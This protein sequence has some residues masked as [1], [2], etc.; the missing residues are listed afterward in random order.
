MTKLQF[1][2]IIIA[3]FVVAAIPFLFD[4]YYATPDDPRYIGLV[5]GAYTG[6]PQRELIYLGSIIGSIEAFLYRKFSDLEWYSIIYNLL[7]LS[8][9]IT[10]ELLLL[11]STLKHYLKY[12]I[13]ALLLVVQIYLTL[14]PQFTLLSTQLGFTS[15]LIMLCAN[16]KKFRYFISFIFFFFAIQLRFVA[17]FIPFM[18]ACPL[19]LYDFRPHN[20]SWWIEKSWVIG[21]I[22]I[23]SLSLIAENK[24]YNTPEWREFNITNDAR[25]Y[26]ADNPIAAEYTG[27]IIDKKERIAYDLFYR[28]RIFD[29]NI[30]TQKDFLKYAKDLHQRTLDNIKINF[31]PYLTI[32]LKMGGGMLFLTACWLLFELLR[33]RQW[34]TLCLLAGSCMLFII[35]NLHMMSYSIYKERV[36]LGCYVSLAFVLSYILLNNARNAKLILTVICII[37]CIQYTKYDYD[38]IQQS[39]YGIS[40]VRETENMILSS[41][42]NKV[43]LLVPTCL[44]PEA[45]HT[46]KSPIYTHSVI[47]GWMHIYPKSNTTFQPFTSF[48]EGLPILVEKSSIEQISLIRELIKMQYGI[49][50]SVTKINESN[51]YILLKLK[52]E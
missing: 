4:I 9:F 44:T 37:T 22:L 32:Y 23:A 51:H 49:S 38:K 24:T 50:T 30:T 26:I 20:R 45:F 27:S 8:S 40:L 3:T 25:G 31:R 41:K 48:T 39:R 6:T 28:F 43:M 5:S 36:M 46:S 7:S 14:S 10:L 1:S 33:K 34:W 17:A 35:A 11:R 12:S 2:F 21:L 52:P 47:Q 16:K 18:I 15:L 29:L 19:F 42:T 13:L